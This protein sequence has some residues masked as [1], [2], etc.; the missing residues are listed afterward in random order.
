MN[1]KYYSLIFVITIFSNRLSLFQQK[2]NRNST[3]TNNLL[4]QKMYNLQVTLY[5]AI[6]IRGEKARD[7]VTDREMTLATIGSHCTQIT[8]Q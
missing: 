2:K 6:P 4:S 7:L 1:K 3:N 8:S 5:T